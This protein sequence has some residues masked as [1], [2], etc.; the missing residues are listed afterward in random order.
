[1]SRAKWKKARIS[2]DSTKISGGRRARRF[3]RFRTGLFATARPGP[4]LA[5]LLIVQ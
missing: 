2:A 3:V 4:A 1:M 5:R